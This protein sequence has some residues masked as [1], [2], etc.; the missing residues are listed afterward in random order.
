MSIEKM[1]IDFHFVKQPKCQNYAIIVIPRVLICFHQITVF[2][3][4]E[5]CLHVG[6]EIILF[7]EFTFE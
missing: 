4:Q 6:L 1:A 2:Y 3:T 7:L 5:L